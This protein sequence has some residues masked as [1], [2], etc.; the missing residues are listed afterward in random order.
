MSDVAY[1]IGSCLMDKE[2]E[3][4]EAEL[5]VTYFGALRPK[6]ANLDRTDIDI[7]EVIAEWTLRFPVA[8]ADFN[9]FLVGWSPG[10]PKLTPYSECMTDRAL[11]LLPTR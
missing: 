6:L 9:R 3:R 8:W 2:A 7:D 10:H 11:K 1:F 4:N 5:L